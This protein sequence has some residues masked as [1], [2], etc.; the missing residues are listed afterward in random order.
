MIRSTIATI[1]IIAIA[2]SAFSAQAVEVKSG[3]QMRAERDARLGLVD[4]VDK[5]HN[6]GLFAAFGY[7]AGVIP[8]DVY[9]LEDVG[10]RCD[11]SGA[12]D[13]RSPSRCKRYVSESTKTTFVIRFSPNQDRAFFYKKVGDQKVLVPYVTFTNSTNEMV[14]ASDE[15]RRFASTH[16]LGTGVAVASTSVPS[17]AAAGPQYCA[18]LPPMERIKC[19]QEARST[20][21]A[22]PSATQPANATS[23]CATLSGIAKTVC[24]NG[25]MFLGK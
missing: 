25:A 7:F 20:A 12:P 11:E 15:G 3:T 9:V 24:E 18:S 16:G 5:T 6:G 23:S 17:V 8:D 2:V 19:G 14:Y 22:T 21:R 13:K 10:M 4:R 1:A